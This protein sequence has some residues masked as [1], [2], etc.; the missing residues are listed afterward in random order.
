MQSKSGKE[1]KNEIG[2]DLKR[3]GMSRSLK[4]KTQQQRR[5]ERLKSKSPFSGSP[6][7]GRCRWEARF[8][9]AGRLTGR[10]LLRA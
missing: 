2:K 8:G 3:H 9:S 5:G 6:R 10:R 7:E 1:M 4:K